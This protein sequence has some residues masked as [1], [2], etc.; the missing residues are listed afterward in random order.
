[1]IARVI[2]IFHARNAC[3]TTKRHIT[4]LLSR[5][6]QCIRENMRSALGAASALLVLGR[7]IVP[8][9]VLQQPAQLG[10]ML[11]QRSLRRVSLQRKG[12]IGIER[13]QLLRCGSPM[14]ALLLRLATVVN[15]NGRSSVGHIYVVRIMKRYFSGVEHRLWYM[16]KEEEEEEDEQQQQ[17]QQLHQQPTLCS[18][19]FSLHCSIS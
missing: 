15:H 18:H 4:C 14:S 3:S 2:R 17:Q 6:A 13:L 10:T 8:V 16:H 7:Y 9:H 5:Y 19:I 12:F 1:M 11:S